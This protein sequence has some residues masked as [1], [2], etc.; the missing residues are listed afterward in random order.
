MIPASLIPDLAAAARTSGHDP[1]AI[2]AI[3][4]V[5]SGGRLLARVNGRDEP[6]IRF[7]GHYFDRR[8]TGTKRE[9]ARAAGLSDP[10]AGRV[11]NPASQT[12][13]HAM[14]KRAEAIDAKSARESCS[15]GIGQV[16]GAHWAW[17]GYPS[18][19]ALVEDARS[20]LA[21]QLRLMLAFINKSGL[22][23]ALRKRDWTAFAKGYNGPGFA[24][25]A[26]HTK[27][28]AAYRRYATMDLGGKHPTPAS[29]QDELKQG[30]H[31]SAVESLQRR[32]SACGYPLS[33]DG[34]FGPLTQKAIKAFQRDHGLGETGFADAATLAALES[35]LPLGPGRKSVWQLVTALIRLLARIRWLLP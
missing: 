14:L 25:N 18:V 31:G 13:R 11:K 33:A 1:A 22:S 10:R 28:A 32:L 6:L 8:L 35:A 21:G 27:L 4:E 9:T 20:G 5:E 26:Y 17:L 2:L 16:M 29:R 30:S 34:E 23:D 3:V 24:A 12:S 7:E 19:D 15:W